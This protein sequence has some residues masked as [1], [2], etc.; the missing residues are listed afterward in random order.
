M[1]ECAEREYAPIVMFVYNRAD[2]FAQTYRAL[3]RCP[4]AIKSDLYVFSDGAKNNDSTAGVIEVRAAIHKAERDGKFRSVSIVESPSNKGLEKSVIFGVSQV[5]SKYGRVIV[6]EDD[7]VVSP[8]FL[9]FMNRCLDTYSSNRKVGS[10]AGYAPEMDYLAK[11][12]QDVFFA[13]RSCSMSWATWEDR[14]ATVKWDEPV[15]ERYYEQ[16]TLIRRLN[17]CGSDRFLR[18][19][20]QTKM[21]SSSWSVKFGSQLILN[22]Q[23]TVYPK[24]SYVSNIGCDASGVHSKA[25]DAASMRVDLSKAIQNPKLTDLAYNPEIQRAMKKHYSGGLVSDLKRFAA[26]TAIVIKESLKG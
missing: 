17:S 13:Y 4:E 14:W 2:H 10:I 15:I 7:C 11:I 16:P 1:Q 25:E 5:I 23:C 21:N 26:T 20:R 22:D 24:H 18:L 9:D 19:Y 3:S 12:D 8:F 6:L